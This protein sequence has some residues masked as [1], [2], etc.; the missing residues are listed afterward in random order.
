MGPGGE[1]GFH[2]T[3]GGRPTGSRPTDQPLGRPFDVMSVG[4]GHMR[5]DGAM[6]PF[7]EGAWVTGHSCAMMEDFDH[8]GRQSHLELV[9]D[10]RVGHGIVM[11]LDFHVVV[12]LLCARAHK[13]Q[14]T[15][16]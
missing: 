15:A 13:S 9:F 10:Q 1:N 12:W 7:E 3:C 16:W 14:K 8:L 11:T 5:R 6:A 4:F 2:H